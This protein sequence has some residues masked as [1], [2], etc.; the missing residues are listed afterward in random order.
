VDATGERRQ[1]HDISLCLCIA[2][3]WI[4][5]SLR[6]HAIESL[7]KSVIYLVV[8][9]KRWI[10]WG[11]KKSPKRKQG[12]AQYCTIPRHVIYTCRPITGTE[13]LL[14]LTRLHQRI[15]LHPTTIKTCV[16]NLLH[17]ISLLLYQR[18]ACQLH[19]TKLLHPFWGTCF[20][21]LQYALHKTC[22]CLQYNWWHTVAT[23]DGFGTG[24]RSVSF[25]TYDCM[26]TT[27]TCYVATDCQ[28]LLALLPMNFLLFLCLLPWCQS[29][30]MHIGRGYIRCSRRPRRCL[31]HNHWNWVMC[32]QTLLDIGR[33]T[34]SRRRPTIPC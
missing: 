33:Y 27:S 10:R 15:H 2:H 11:Y 14:F 24:L 7:T 6:R 28:I 29:L 18:P 4:V 30:P 13:L 25:H 22:H 23:C 8:Y 31:V 34:S 21:V 26:S 32:R 17:Y 5:W 9:F 20:S 16:P 12:S 1:A 19:V 3:W